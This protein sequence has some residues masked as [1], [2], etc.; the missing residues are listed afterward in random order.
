MLRIAERIPPLPGGKEIHVSELTRAQANAGHHVRV[1]F[2][3]GDGRSLAAPS[4]RVTPTIPTGHVG[5]A[6]GSGLFAVAAARQV[7]RIRRPDVIHAH[8]DWPEAWGIGR[9]AHRLGIAFVMTVHGGLNPRHVLP[10][11][12]CFAGVDAFIALGERVRIDLERCGVPAERITVMSSGVDTELICSASA[13]VVREPGLIVT[14]GSLDRVKNTESVIRAV[15]AIPE[16]I[17][18][19]LE[20]IGDGPQMA[21]L[22]ALAGGSPRIR[23]SG[24]L[25]R[26]EVYRR[27]AA[28]DAFVIASRRL[29]DK[30]E[31]VPTAL[32]E[33]MAL[34]RPCLVSTAATPQPVVPDN[35]SYRTFDPQ[36]HPGLRGLIVEVLTDEF[37]R[38]ELGVRARAAVVDLAWPAVARRVDEVYARA[39]SR[40]RERQ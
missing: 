17:R 10:S 3:S 23:F 29:P 34:G 7:M 26:P 38:T 8:G 15:L 40:R 16:P 5:G 18:V 25:A 9:C 13:G 27:V 12:V 36:D 11:R 39:R 6:I 24:R 37:L 35:G 4:V 14:V 32:L 31:G 22:V 20:V 30:G 33:A 2:R 28:A 21:D 1:L 19:V